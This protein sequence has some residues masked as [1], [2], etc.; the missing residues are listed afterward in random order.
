V[1]AFHERLTD[2]SVM[3]PAARFVGAVGAERSPFPADKVV[4]PVKSNP[5]IRTNTA[6]P[7]NSRE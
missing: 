7:A 6:I 1:E 2:L 3:P 4:E 5:T